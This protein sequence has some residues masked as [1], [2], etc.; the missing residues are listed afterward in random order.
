MHDGNKPG[1]LRGSYQQASFIFHWEPSGWGWGRME[2]GG[3]T[4]GVWGATAAGSGD[5]YAEAAFGMDRQI[6]HHKLNDPNSEMFL[7]HG[8]DTDTRDG[9]PV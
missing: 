3:E 8:T 6:T 1:A 5:K 9:Q 2:S 4:K 7:D